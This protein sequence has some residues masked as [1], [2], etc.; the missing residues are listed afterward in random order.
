MAKNE[1]RK[2]TFSRAAVLACVVV[3]GLGITQFIAGDG[4]NPFHLA[5]VFVFIWIGGGFLFQFVLEHFVNQKV[6]I[7]YQMIQSSKDFNK[8]KS[9]SFEDLDRDVRQWLIE[10]QDKLAQF[11]TQESFRREFMGNVS[12]ELKTPIFNIQ[13]YI[14]SLLDGAVYDENFNIKYLSRAMK[15]VDRMI[16]LVEDLEVISRLETAGIKLEKTSFDL[17]TLV[18]D[19]MDSLE[20]KA[21][22]K[23]VQL[24][25]NYPEAKSLMVFADRKRMQ[26]VLEN[27]V[28]NGIK[29][30]KE[31]GQVNVQFYKLDQNVLVEVIDD[32]IGIDEA[33]LPRVFERFYRVDKARTIKK[34][35]GSG[36]GLSIVKHIIEAH[37]QAIRVRSTVGKGSVFSFTIAL[38]KSGA[39]TKK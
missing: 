23:N 9:G 15:S 1:Y 24:K 2:L 12:H 3:I 8:S 19:V 25:F 30:G 33:S 31:G 13:G 35:T 20:F 36:L 14:M 16:D 6:N 26:Q 10:S 4:V 32:G 34:S 29:Y 11:E 38:A 22:K 28:V 17:L 5:I 18:Q 37:G 27:L 7:I 21:K 39:K